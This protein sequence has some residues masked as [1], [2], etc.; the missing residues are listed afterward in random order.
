MK[1]I[2]SRTTLLALSLV[3]GSIPVNA[4]IERGK[5]LHDQS[6]MG[7]HDNSVYQRTNKKIPTLQALHAQVHRCTKPAGADWS[8]EDR[9]DVVNYLNQSFYRYK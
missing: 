5:V 2:S 6:C 1:A 8:K 3:M 4:D 9:A 7:C